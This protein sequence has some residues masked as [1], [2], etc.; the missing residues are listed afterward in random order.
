MDVLSQITKNSQLKEE[1]YQKSIDEIKQDIVA[2]EI[3][4]EK[5]HNQYEE[6]RN[7]LKASD[8]ISIIYTVVLDV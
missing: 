5:L 2:R 8:L 1:Q 3:E 6:L 7:I 4:L